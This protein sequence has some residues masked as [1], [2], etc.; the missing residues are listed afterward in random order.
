MKRILALVFVVLLS[1]SALSL[2]SCSRPSGLDKSKL[3]GEYT[4]D[5]AGT[6]LKVYNWGEYISDGKMGSI[7]VNKA[8]EEVT[9]IKVE[10]SF[11]DDN[12]SMYSTLDAGTTY[13]DIVIPSDYMIQ[14]LI[15]NDMLK[16]VDVTK[17]SNYKYISDDYKNLYF[18]PNNEYSV[19]YTVG[20]V[21]LIYNTK[22]VKEA[23]TSWTALWDKEY[24]GDILMFNNP[25]DAFAIAQSILGL[26]Q[27]SLDKTTWDKAAD[28]LVEQR[29]V[30]DA[31]VMDQVF[32]KMESGNA[33][34]A[35]YYAGDFISMQENNPDLAFVYPE[36]GVNMFCDSICIPSNAQNYEAALL[37][38]NFMMEPEIAL[39]NAEYIH[40]ASPNTAVIN[41]DAYSFKGNETLYPNDKKKT[42]QFK[43]LDPEIIKYYSELWATKVKVSNK[44]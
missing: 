18:D 41:N 33:A 3:E 16:K 23:P 4:R 7:D 38:M 15:S 14:R 24:A 22:L 34:L 17:L 2:T 13:Y 5:L 21:G 32:S 1:F 44:Q 28:L 12:E 25:R 31:Y 9:G 10:Y 27:N 39:A 8:F 37:Y 20:M 36:E 11:F 35:P 40:Y 29:G 26:D 30:L 43:D 6:I 19:P 42:F